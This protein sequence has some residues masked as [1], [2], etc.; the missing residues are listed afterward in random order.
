MSRLYTRRRLSLYHICL[1]QIRMLAFGW[2]AAILL[3]RTGIPVE[4]QVGLFWFSLLFGLVAG[5]IE[6]ALLKRGNKNLP[7]RCRVFPCE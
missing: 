7:L 1:P 4:W 2:G 5:G 6:L 3:P